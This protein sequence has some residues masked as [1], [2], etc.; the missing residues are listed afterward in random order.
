MQ[1]YPI[2]N[3]DDFGLSPASNRGTIEVHRDEFVAS[4]SLMARTDGDYGSSGLL[5]QRLG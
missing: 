4:A 1:I 5:R 3:A 2:L